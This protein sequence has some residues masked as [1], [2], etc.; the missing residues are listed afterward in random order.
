MRKA[1]VHVSACTGIQISQAE[2]WK[3]TNGLAVRAKSAN[4]GLAS[5]S[6]WIGLFARMNPW[7]DIGQM[8]APVGPQ[9]CASLRAQDK[10]R[11]PKPETDP[12]TPLS[13]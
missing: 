9:T 2:G 10:A 13:D 4:K 11:R 6:L 1:L 8:D 3:M 5:M 7:V 12:E